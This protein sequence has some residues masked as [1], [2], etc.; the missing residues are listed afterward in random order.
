MSDETGIWK[1]S[2][3]LYCKKKTLIPIMIAKL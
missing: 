2:K 1:Y 3:C